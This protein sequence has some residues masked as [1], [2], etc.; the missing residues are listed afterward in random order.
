MT[1]EFSAACFQCMQEIELDLTCKVFC[2]AYFYNFNIFYGSIIN[3]IIKS[4]LGEDLVWQWFLLR[5]D[6]M[7]HYIIIA[8]CWNSFFQTNRNICKSFRLFIST[9]YSDK[10]QKFLILSLLSS[11]ALPPHYSIFLSCLYLA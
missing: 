4:S 8:F 7:A 6:V 1:R 11:Y 3:I 9:R 10:H 5:T 2:Y